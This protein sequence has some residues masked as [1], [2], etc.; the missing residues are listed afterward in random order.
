MAV[1]GGYETVRELY[2][3]GLASSSTA[4][5]AGGG[6][7]AYV[8]KCLSPLGAEMTAEQAERQVEAFLEGARAHQQ[9]VRSGA[10]HWAAL[11]ELGK[12][13]GG[14][15]FVTDYHPRSIRHLVRGQVKLDGRG[16]HALVTGVIEGL[17][18]FQAACKRPHG[19]LKVSNILLA[20]KGGLSSSA[21]LLTDPAPSADIDPKL[22]DV[23][24]F[25]AIGELIY[26]LV[27][28]RTGR[29]MGGWPAPE[30]AEW[31]RLGRNGENWRQLCNRLL[32]PNLSPGLL[33]LE[34][35]AGDVRK[36]R[37]GRKISPVFA[38]VALV[39]L[40]V[41][42]AGGD[43]T[44]RGPNSIVGKL[45]APGGGSTVVDRADWDRLCAEYRG[46][47]T[48]LR[49]EVGEQDVEKWAADPYLKGK[50]L[51]VLK[52]VL[53][54]QV[55]VSPHRMAPPGTDLRFWSPTAEAV[56]KSSA[57]LKALAAAR[58][59]LESEG[60][61]ALADV[62]QSAEEYSRHGWEAP[63]AYLRKLAAMNGEQAARRVAGILR[64]RP[65]QQTVRQRWGDVVKLAEQI[66]AWGGPGLT[67]ERLE[68]YARSE[69]GSSADQAG[70]EC[71]TELD[72]KLSS[73]LA[74]GGLLR[75]LEAFVSGP[76]AKQLDMGEVRKNSP[77]QLAAGDKMTDEVLRR[78]LAK[79]RGGTYAPRPDP[80]TPQWRAG[81]NDTLAA[82]RSDRKNVA[83][84]A[85][86]LLQSA[87]ID[88]EDRRQ[89]QA[90]ARDVEATQTRLTGAAE[91][92]G[93]VLGPAA[94]DSG[95]RQ[96]VD[97]GMRSLEGDV[98]GA[99]EAVRQ[100]AR[101][102]SDVRK[103]IAAKLSRS[104][105]DYVAALRG[106]QRVSPTGS[107]EV[108]AAWVA[109]RDALIAAAEPTKD[110]ASL[111]AKT[112]RLEAFLRDLES[113]LA[114]ELPRKVEARPWCGALL[115]PE[116][117]QRRRSAAI[118]SMLSYVNWDSVVAGGK[119]ADF[120]SRSQQVVKAYDAWRNGLVDLVEG[121]NRVED[122]L[123]L[124]FLTGEKPPAGGTLGEAYAAQQGSAILKD[125]AVAKAVAPLVSRVEALKVVESAGD[126]A[127]LV[128]LASAATQDRFEAARVAWRRLGEVGKPWPG[129]R[130][131]VGQELEFEK[132]LA[133]VYDLVR[134]E[135]RKAALKKELAAGGPGRW[136]AYFLACSDPAEIEDA[137]ARM[138]P[139]GL[140][141]AKAASLSPAVGY[142]LLMHE[143]RRAVGPQAAAAED[144]AVQAAVANFQKAVAALGGG[145]AK[146]PDVSA[147]LAKLEEIRTASG[148]G[149]DLTKA[150]PALAGW[151]KSEETEGAVT[152]SWEGRG[153]RLSFRR[154]EPPGGKACF[155][156]TTE[157]P[158]GLFIDVVMGTRKWPEVS[159]LLRNYDP[160]VED[161][162]EG[163]RV[164]RLESGRIALGEKWLFTNPAMGEDPAGYYPPGRRP[165]KI[166]PDHPMQQV[167][168]GAAMY[169]ARLLGC[170]LPSSA[171]W[172]AAQQINARSGASALPN[173]RDQT[174]A[175]QRDF[176]FSL[177]SQG[178]AGPEFYADAGI[179]WPKGMR[180]R[181]EG[182][183]A[184]IV[185]QND[186]VLWFAKVG[187][188]TQRPFG[189]LT[190]NVAEY[191]Y[192]DPD[193]MSK[194]SAA[195]ADDMRKFLET[196]AAAAR[197]IGGSALS[198]PEVPLDKPQ[199]IEATGA[200]DG[201]AD[202]GFRL[203]FFAG[204]ERL[205]GRLW[206][207]L[208]AAPAQ[209]YLTQLGP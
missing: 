94:Y 38:V 33:S 59:A 70:P 174:W 108:D 160:T 10:K 88:A 143:F 81:V 8:V 180:D 19:N 135:A 166:E 163:P 178:K 27:L 207:L 64:V 157:V 83:D 65:M 113:P 14:A 182:K 202:V 119:D 62:K 69:T 90:V 195:G 49:N 196:G 209:G 84:E 151:A 86:K 190:G 21:V 52:P 80:R 156:S 201:F 194:L 172:Q 191:V 134:D 17:I 32:N 85:A 133:A 181:K 205:Q 177:E 54:G 208:A 206:R 42:A 162:R 67:T 40:L 139:F 120:A 155:L 153:R 184:T 187:S 105:S 51:P 96:T 2:R 188:D 87:K 168:L 29:A 44:L 43:Y 5:K 170:R 30:G 23:P 39:V 93:K 141:R 152:Y 16:I 165:S 57:A 3:G 99:G 36:L 186:G 164:W 115:T 107:A 11:H 109:R 124:G 169:F 25:H 61:P 106:R 68:E 126:K 123:R 41:G 24:D 4:R 63:A 97:E 71:L 140:D 154:A 74:E 89:I 132:N 75:E 78:G 28:L 193:A 122:L 9:A 200:K 159:R 137:A 91:L 7:E 103:S 144:G 101:R 142:R 15:F 77:F 20:G 117:L 73:L 204:R 31:T 173:L 185:S 125:A 147:L 197:V 116:E 129:T 199:E 148:G 72:G 179:F 145:F 100:A 203:A 128:K 104:W 98:K 192:E 149:V 136:R 82:L 66:A 158:V 55:E 53:S 112:D 50:V 76:Q 79:L 46:W 118:Q 34:D 47:Y 130:A 131:E 176:A 111:S 6:A 60:W 95:T 110:V 189:H 198:A 92:L 175:A 161:P 183:A 102:L 138:G 26:Q 35:L 1:F 56:E 114:G 121:F 13:D 146:R 22:G 18:E 37:E 150:G 167:T 127:A 48:T 45:F 171:E 58:T 12:A